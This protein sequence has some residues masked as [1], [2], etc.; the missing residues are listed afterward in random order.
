MGCHSYYHIISNSLLDYCLLTWVARISFADMTTNIIEIK[1]RCAD[2]DLVRARLKELGAREIGTDT[3]VDTYF[4]V[5][6]GRLKLRRG[7]IE[8]NLIYYRRPEQ[9]GPKHSEV[10]LY[11][12]ADAESLQTL[13]AQALPTD[14]V[15]VKKRSIYF[16]DNVKVHLDNVKSL[17]SFIEIEAIDQ[18]GKFSLEE[19]RS[20]CEALMVT[21]GVDTTQLIKHSYSD[22]I[23]KAND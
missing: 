23:R 19:L 3:Q 16:V 21:L 4:N 22:M 6:E 2:P 13:L 11:R 5:G 18:P 12:P 17:G 14:V 10:Q 20:Q 7:E 15:V 9:A 1:A 8:T